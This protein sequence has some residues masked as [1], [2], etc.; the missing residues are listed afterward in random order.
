MQLY[1]YNYGNTI[2]YIDV[3]AEG[4]PKGPPFHRDPGSMDPNLLQ[5]RLFSQR[6]A[7]KV[8]SLL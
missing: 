3:H 5:Y 4:I 7:L 2:A 6:K 8:G 1:C